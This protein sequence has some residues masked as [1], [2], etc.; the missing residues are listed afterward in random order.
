MISG[1]YL[2]GDVR[3]GNTPRVEVSKHRTTHDPP[4]TVRM[5]LGNGECEMTTAQWL[6]FTSKVSDALREEGL[7]R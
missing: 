2:D 6:E 7:L 1:R 3:S 4:L 5:E